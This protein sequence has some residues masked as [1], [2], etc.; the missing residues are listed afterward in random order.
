MV[1]VV[2]Q[3]LNDTVNIRRHWQLLIKYK[4]LQLASAC[5]LTLAK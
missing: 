2:R 5:A 3:L 4:V 1:D